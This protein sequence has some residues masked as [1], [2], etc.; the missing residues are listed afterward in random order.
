MR[1]HYGL[2]AI[3]LWIANGSA[4]RA[5]A[6]PTLESVIPGVGSRG[7][8]FTVLM[9]GGGLKDACE[10]MFYD[11][12]LSVLKLEAVSDSEATATLDASADCRIGAHPLRLRTPRGL[13]EL[14][15]I[16]IS[17]FPVTAEVEPNDSVKQAHHLALNSTISGVIDSGDVDSFVVTL[18]KGQRFSAEVEAVRLGGEMT[19]TVLKILGPG[20]RMLAQ[21]D[22][23]AITRQDPFA[24]LVAPSDG[25]YTVQ[26]RDTAF[27]GGPTSSYALHV[28]DFIR[29]IGVFPPGGQAGKDVRLKMLLPGSDDAFLAV[30]FPEN[31]SRW[32]NY[33]PTLDGTTAPTATA[34]RVSPYRCVDEAESTQVSSLTSDQ[35]KVHEWPIAFHGVI[36]RPKEADSFAIKARAGE[37]VQVEV[38]AERIGSKLDSVVEIINPERQVIARSDDDACQ[39]S[40]IV[41]RPESDGVYQI[42][43]SDKRRGGG[44]AFPYRIEVEAPT[45]ALEVFLPGLV[46]KSQTGQ[47]ISVPR[48]NRVLAYLGVR[49]DGFDGAVHLDV[50]GLPKGVSLDV[51][52]IPAGTYLTPIVVEATAEAP[53]S[54]SLV[55]VTGVSA[56]QGGTIRGGFQQTVDLVPGTGDSSY[57][58]VTVDRL[59]VVVTEGAPYRV[60]LEKPKASLVCDGAIEVVTTVERAKGFDHAVE[61][62]F[63]YLPPGVEMEGPIVLSAT[64]PKAVFRLFARPDAD[65]VSWRLAAAV[66]IAPPRLDRRAMTLALQNTIDPNAAGGTG[67]RR[68]VRVETGPEVSSDFVPMELRTSRI[69]GRFDALAVEQGKTAIVACHLEMSSPI[70]ASMEATLEGLPARV[71][72]R[73]VSLKSGQLRVEFPVTISPSTPTGEY[74]SL[75]CRMTRRVDGLAVIDQVGR[76][77][78]LKVVAPGTLTMGAGGKP[79]GPLD[80]LRQRAQTVEQRKKP[81]DIGSNPRATTGTGSNGP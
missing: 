17:R 31:A 80:A 79:L 15:V 65:P 47:V 48:G 68:R 55:C 41:F 3:C 24:S 30:K 10:I 81:G 32:W 66:K 62:K 19:D 50:S 63:P 35:L 54:A 25:G 11:R 51:Q 64:E 7:S 60:K 57:Q 1:G 76:G 6:G 21:A 13:S 5:A 34:L 14:K 44:P 70:S 77:G 42:Q 72:T 74:A 69:S 53:L 23:T 16:Y 71:S 52:D 56:T 75:V 8:Q 2:L 36:G 9:S 67:R 18:R 26:V 61:V 78:L 27:G 46:R 37:V 58:S 12:G 29:P 38:F 73:P 40:R 45:P 22:D 49:R 20:G 33:F 39:D 28:G 59:A 43:I 4:V